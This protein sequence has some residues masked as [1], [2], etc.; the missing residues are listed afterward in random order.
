[1]KKGRFQIHEHEQLRHH[2]AHLWGA[3]HALLQ[4]DEHL[5]RLH[6]EDIEGDLMAHT[7]CHPRPKKKKKKPKKGR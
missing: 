6:L 2:L 4:R 1:M 3:I 7:P 5:A